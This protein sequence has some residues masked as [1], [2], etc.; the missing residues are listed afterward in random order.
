MYNRLS[1]LELWV[2]SHFIHII[3]LF[4]LHFHR[5]IGILTALRFLGSPQLVIGVSQIPFF[6]HSRDVESLVKLLFIHFFVKWF[7]LRVDK[8]HV[9]FSGFRYWNQSYV[10][11][12]I[13]VFDASDTVIVDCLLLW[14]FYQVFFVVFMLCK[15]HLKI[16]Y[17]TDLLI[18]RIDPENSSPKFL[19]RIIRLK[20]ALSLSQLL[21]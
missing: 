11:R 16:Y 5:D 14:N 15:I 2:A 8:F 9:T 7:F 13:S 10:W 17:P 12:V 1:R 19:L 20:C 21:E 3:L 18:P 6:V 4:T